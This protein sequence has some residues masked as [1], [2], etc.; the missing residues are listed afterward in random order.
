LNIRSVRYM[1]QFRY[2]QELQ[3]GKL[4]RLFH[5]LSSWLICLFRFG[6]HV[7]W[8]LI[9]LIFSVA[10]VMRV[11]QAV[12][13][14]PPIPEQMNFHKFIAVFIA[15]CFYCCSSPIPQ[16]THVC[17]LLSGTYFY[18]TDPRSN[19]WNC[20]DFIKLSTLFLLAFL[21]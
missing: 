19:M 6:N 4:A 7:L 15:S 8:I 13:L 16:F 3:V 21:V 12:C 1:L 5:L 18:R 17:V 14:P 10:S 11:T 20:Y 2:L 9:T